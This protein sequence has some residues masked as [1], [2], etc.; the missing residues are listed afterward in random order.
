MSSQQQEVSKDHQCQS[1]ALA[2]IV[3]TVIQMIVMIMYI[4]GAAWFDRSQVAFTISMV[5]VITFLGSC[6]IGN[7]LIRQMHKPDLSDHFSAT[8]NGYWKSVWRHH[9]LIHVLALMICAG[10]LM[11]YVIND[12]SWEVI[13]GLAVIGVCNLLEALVWEDCDLARRSRSD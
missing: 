6:L 5:L 8:G 2:C 10:L 12:Y 11:H 13:V 4:L 9:Q 1:L 3:N 7:W